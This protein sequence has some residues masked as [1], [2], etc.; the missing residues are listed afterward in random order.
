M[1]FD[2]LLTRSEQR[3]REFRDVPVCLD[4][5]L[6]REKENLLAALEEAKALDAKDK[7]LAGPSDVN[8][9][10]I[11]ERL[12]ALAVAAK[13]ALVMLRFYKLPGDAWNELTSHFP[14]RADVPVDRHFGYNIDGIVPA[15][16]AFKRDGVAYGVRLDGAGDDAVEVELTDTQWTRL[17]GVISGPEVGDIQDAIWSMNEIDPGRRLDALV[18]G[19]GAARSSET[20]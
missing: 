18:K 3:P 4:A 15:A 16:A 8:A 11:Q 5:D 10:P 20:K 13:D 17:L 6:A 9:A 7:R 1:D 12:D 14:V 19:Y 2:D